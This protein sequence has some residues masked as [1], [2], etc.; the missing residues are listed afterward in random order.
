MLLPRQRHNK[1][2]QIWRRL[3][4]PHFSS[5]SSLLCQMWRAAVLEV[6]GDLSGWHAAEMTYFMTPTLDFSLS[7][8]PSLSSS[9]DFSFPVFFSTCMPHYILKVNPI[10]TEITLEVK[11][12]R[13]IYLSIYFLVLLP[14]HWVLSSICHQQYLQVGI[15]EATSSILTRLTTLA[16]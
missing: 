7:A 3:R 5:M 12:P 16:P 15:L 9:A 2:I 4:Q 11:L 10:N 6:T 13:G 1:C 8:S 14:L